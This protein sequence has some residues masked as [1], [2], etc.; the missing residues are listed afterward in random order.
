MKVGEIFEITTISNAAEDLDYLYNRTKDSGSKTYYMLKRI[1][2]NWHTEIH[3]RMGTGATSHKDINK[4]TVLLNY[5]QLY[6]KAKNKGDDEVSNYSKKIYNKTIK[7]IKSKFRLREETVSGVLEKQKGFQYQLKQ[8]GKK[9]YIYHAGKNRKAFPKGVEKLVD[10]PIIV[11]L[12]LN[13]TSAT[14]SRWSPKIRR[15]IISRY[16]EQL[17]KTLEE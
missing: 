17:K 8:K 7:E 15:K 14:F 10:L 13:K 16:V 5:A 11:K 1:I 3:G 6:I 4:L 2:S 9:F 12:F